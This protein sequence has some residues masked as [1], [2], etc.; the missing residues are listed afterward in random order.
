ML[1]TLQGVY[2]QGEPEKT[3]SVDKEYVSSQAPIVKQRLQQAGVRLAML[4]NQALSS[5]L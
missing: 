3:V 2:R 1:M 5:F 4:L